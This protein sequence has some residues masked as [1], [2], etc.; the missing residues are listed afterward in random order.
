MIAERIEGKKG[1]RSSKVIVVFPGRMYAWNAMAISDAFS[2][3][4]ILTHPTRK[5]DIDIKKINQ[6]RQ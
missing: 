5:P 1:F 3:P 2:C 6:R 4:I